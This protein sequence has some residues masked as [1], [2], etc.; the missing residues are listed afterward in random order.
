MVVFPHD[1][2]CVPIGKAAGRATAGSGDLLAMISLAIVY[3]PCWSQ[4]SSRKALCFSCVM[5]FHAYAH[6]FA[7]VLFRFIRTLSILVSTGGFN[8]KQQDLIT[9][10]NN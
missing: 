6:D 9:Q 8:K 2:H 3:F 7:T 4:I 5:T 1:F 10:A